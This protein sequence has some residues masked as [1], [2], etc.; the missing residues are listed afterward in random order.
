MT[1]GSR[2]SHG[3]PGEPGTGPDAGRGSGRGGRRA[4][5][6]VRGSRPV[7]GVG[8]VTRA[9]TAGTAARRG[10]DRDSVTADVTSG[11]RVTAGY[12]WR[13]LVLGAAAYAC[14]KILGRLQLVA[15]ALFLALVV[16]SVLRPAANLLARWLPRGLATAVSLVGSVVVVLGLLALV[17]GL[18]AG[19]SGRLGEEFAGGAGRIE[20]WLEGSPFHVDH[21][22]LANLQDKATAYLSQHRSTLLS[23]A[24]SGAGRVLE[25]LAGGVLALFCSLFF[26]HSGERFW[27]W[28]QAL[29][30]E[31]A[32]DPWDRAGRAAW[33]TFAGYTRGI[34]IVAATNAVV[35][36]IAL[37]LLGVP[38]ALPLM[39][40]EFFAA[41]VPLVGSPVALAVA[42]VVAL[43]SRGPVVALVVLAL[44][45]V[46]GQLEGHVL[47]PLVLSWAVRLHP[48]VVALSVIAGGVLAGV[49][50]A[51][52][53]VPMVSVAWSVFGA[54]RA[55]PAPPVPDPH[56]TDKTHL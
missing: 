38:L 7:G 4:R 43:A 17:G 8:A 27:H 1:D 46:V 12:A 20:R 2:R 18:V 3:R 9:R 48:V 11:L 56:A 35:V 45:V 10:G 31:R 36:G 55:P 49:I 30:P 29:L 16:T 50:G 44:I 6:V 52:V 22:A 24:L 25:V 5:Y 26:I 40:L 15:V 54:L 19:E 51:V 47:H 37:F 41:F 42:T 14:F 28:F 33:R 53:A 21:A 13:L 32:R 23:S 34:I 39:L